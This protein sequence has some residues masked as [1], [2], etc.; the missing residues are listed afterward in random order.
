MNLANNPGS[1]IE[2]MCQC[3]DILKSELHKAKLDITLYEEIINMLLE[4]QFS[5]QLKQS[6]TNGHLCEEK[7]F[8]PKSR[9]DT[10]K[11]SPGIGS[12]RSNLIQIIPAIN[13][14]E[15]LGNLNDA[16]EYECVG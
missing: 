6:E 2:N 7:Y 9:V 4:E 16:T 15:V 3:S 11:V 8:Y 10:A 13:K 12:N 1:I 14:Y 5:S